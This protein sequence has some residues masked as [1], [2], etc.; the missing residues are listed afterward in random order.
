M[1]P[2]LAHIMKKRRDCKR[3]HG[4]G[5]YADPNCTVD[6]RQMSISAQAATKEHTLPCP[7]CGAN[8]NPKKR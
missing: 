1:T 8:A 7:V 4:Y 6:G 5:L 2:L 3:C